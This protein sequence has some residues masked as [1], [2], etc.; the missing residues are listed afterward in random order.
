MTFSV[1][2]LRGNFGKFAFNV[3]TSSTFWVMD[4]I[5]AFKTFSKTFSW[6]LNSLFV[7]SKESAQRIMVSYCLRSVFPLWSFWAVLKIEIKTW[8]NMSIT[9]AAAVL[10]ANKSQ[11]EKFQ[12]ISWIVKVSKGGW[13]EALFRAIKENWLVWVFFGWIRN[14]RRS[15]FKQ[16]SGGHRRV[17]RACNPI[18][19]SSEAE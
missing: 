11:T 19:W 15:F 2:A 12:Q 14:S 1:T 7:I 18:N 6:N 3:E 16:T 17:A 9:P 5:A 10:K 4:V 8:P 13:R